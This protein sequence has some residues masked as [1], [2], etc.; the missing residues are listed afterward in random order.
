M[1]IGAILMCPVDTIKTRLQFQGNLSGV[2]KY[3]GGLHAFKTIYNEEGL[4]GFTRGIVD[5]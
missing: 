5:K 4:F 3:D 2:T 1:R